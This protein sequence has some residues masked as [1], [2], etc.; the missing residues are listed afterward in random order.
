MPNSRKLGF[1]CAALAVAA[2]TVGFSIEA[3]AAKKQVTAVEGVAAMH[4]IV[5]VGNRLCFDGH[6][7]Y[8]SSGGEPT[9]AAAQAAAIDSW[10]QLVD[11]EYGADWSKFS[12][13]NNKKVECSQS[14]NGWGCDVESIPCR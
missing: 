8:G 6:Y 12:K 3:D 4:E 11:L 10:F 14:A 13:S 2:T 5:R 9:K 7:H 1:T